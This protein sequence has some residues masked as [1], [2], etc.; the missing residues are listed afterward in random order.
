[1]LAKVAQFNNEDFSVRVDRLSSLLEPIMMG[2]LGV[3]AA[4]LV[5]GLYLPIFQMSGS[6]H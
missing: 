4:I 3:V 6:I 5:L 2:G 1:M